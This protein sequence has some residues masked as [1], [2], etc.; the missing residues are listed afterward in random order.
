MKGRREGT[1]KT[2]MFFLRRNGGLYF[3][4]ARTYAASEKIK[5]FAASFFIFWVGRFRR[6]TPL[7]HHKFMIQNTRA[8]PIDD[9]LT[10]LTN[11]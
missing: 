3:S 5:E 4:I 7:P 8:E 11:F 10:L 2:K 6:S 1:T 9:T